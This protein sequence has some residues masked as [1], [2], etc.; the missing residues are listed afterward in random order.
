MVGM[1]PQQRRQSARPALRLSRGAE[2][3]LTGRPEVVSWQ[4]RP[5]ADAM[6]AGVYSL[7]PRVDFYTTGWQTAL[8]R[9]PEIQSLEMSWTLNAPSVVTFSTEMADVRVLGFRFP[10]S[11]TWKSFTNKDDSADGIDEKSGDGVS[12]PSSSRL[13]V[14]PRIRK[15]RRPTRMLPPQDVIKLEDRLYYLLQPPLESLAHGAS[16]RFPFEPFP[17]QYEGVAFLY[18]RFSAI[19]ADEMGLGKTMQA[20][21]TI[22]MLL[23][24]GEIRNVLLV[25]PKPLVSN[26]KREFALWAPEIPVM[27]V[28]GDSAKRDW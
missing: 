25:C 4:N 11:A 28:E 14:Q 2:N 20:I 19:L 8:K 17:Y 15:G 6:R 24:S 23:F 10:E 16:L 3:S 18:P 26:W 21:T 1:V 13:Q 27:V 5:V 12:R 22:R 7:L 9:N